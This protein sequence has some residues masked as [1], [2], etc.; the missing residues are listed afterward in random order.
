MPEKGRLDRPFFLA[1]NGC[2][3]AFSF[4]INKET[5]RPATNEPRGF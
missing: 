5:L 4:V 3:A 2:V 1:N